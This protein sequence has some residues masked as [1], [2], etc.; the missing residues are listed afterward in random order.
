MIYLIGGPPR[1]GKTTVA[2]TLAKHL[3]IP[4]ISADT[5]ESIVSQTLLDVYGSKQNSHYA[6]LFPKDALRRATDGSNDHL[7]ASN[8]PEMIA[9]AYRVQGKTTRKAIETLVACEVSEGHDYII[10]GH[11]VQPAL[12]HYLSQERYAGQVRTLFLVKQDLDSVVAGL[13]ANVGHN[14]WAQLKTGT[15]ATYLKIAEMITAYSNW[16]I[17]EARQTN[18]PFLD[19]DNGGFENQVKYAVEQLKGNQ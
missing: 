6:A 8:T 11:Q 13:K 14:D 9:E 12:A 7:Y 15:G 4:W 17:Q 2:K 18:Q 16:F 1:C 10:E 3:G 19:M 5:L